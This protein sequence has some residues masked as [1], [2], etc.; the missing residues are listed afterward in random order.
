[1]KQSVHD[2]LE[3]AN[4]PVEKGGNMPVETGT[5]RAS[6]L[7][8][9]NEPSDR[10]LF[11]GDIEPAEDIEISIP[12][13]EA[14]DTLYGT[15]TANYAGYVEYGT[16][17]DEDTEGRAPIYFLTQAAGNWQSIV[18]RNATELARRLNL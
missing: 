6:L 13:F 12:A 3:E 14:G 17:G 2:L 18:D 1:M 8:T 11:Q 10:V 15:W 16:E 4:T 5:L 7:V 9:I